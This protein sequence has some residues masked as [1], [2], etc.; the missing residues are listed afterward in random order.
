MNAWVW[1]LQRISAALLLIILGLH[2]WLIYVTNP[3]EVISF[4]EA[5]GRLT[6]ASYIVL[7]ALLLLFGL[8][9]AFNGLYA[10]MVDMG[11]KARLIT[12]CILLVVGLALLVSGMYSVLQYII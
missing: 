2:V 3:V 12:I 9:H 8:F 5:K 11:L 7:Y 10:V 6:S 1:L 4:D